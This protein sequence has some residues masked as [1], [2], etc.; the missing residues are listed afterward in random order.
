MVISATTGVI[1]SWKKD[2]T[3]L[4]PPT[5]DG[6]ATDLQDWLP[7]HQL[8]TTAVGALGAQLESDE[9]SQPTPD[10]LTPERLDVRP[11]NG[12]VKVRFPG[13]WEVQVDGATGAVL[14]LG[15]RHADWIEAIHDGSIISDGFKL[16]S[17]NV[18]GLGLLALGVSGFWMWWGPKRLRKRRLEER[19]N[20]E[21]ETG[22]D[23]SE[24]GE[25]RLRRG[26]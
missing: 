5:R 20:T 13:A 21:K 11:D 23:P 17:M 9:A 19:A 10:R 24:S 3:A 26:A 6:T 25:E 4:Q 14:S 7:L 15:R 8:A 22:T 1:L 12:V 2:V 18:L 16:L